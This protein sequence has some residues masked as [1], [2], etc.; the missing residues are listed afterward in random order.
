MKRK[1]KVQL[2]VKKPIQ[3]ISQ[4][5]LDR[6]HATLW[7]TLT[8]GVFIVT[9]ILAIVLGAWGFMPFVYG[10]LAMLAILLLE[11]LF[12]GRLW[13]FEPYFSRSFGH[14]EASR[15]L[16]IFSGGFLLILETAILLNVMVR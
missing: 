7:A 8:F 9:Y 16:L 2:K 11:A 15:R 5:S 13:P 6:L 12:R 1:S 4:E 14:P 3:E 10:A